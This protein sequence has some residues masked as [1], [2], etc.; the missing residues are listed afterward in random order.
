MGI[1]HLVTI[2][3]PLLLDVTKH[4]G[5]KEGGGGEGEGWER[6]E[7]G[8][9]IMLVCHGFNCGAPVLATAP[10]GSCGATDG[11]PADGLMHRK[12]PAVGRWPGL[13]PEL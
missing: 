6:Q 13:G 10:L 8:E 1:H 12:T 11:V 9:Q 4:S 2:T 3:S 5:L 7:S